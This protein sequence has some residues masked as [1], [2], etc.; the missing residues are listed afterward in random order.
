MAEP[1][2]LIRG[3]VPRSSDTEWFRWA[4]ICGA[5]WNI[6]GS[7]PELKPKPTDTLRRLKDKTEQILDT[8]P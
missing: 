5:A 4:R 8:T 3:D 6:K 1:S 7:E 2:W